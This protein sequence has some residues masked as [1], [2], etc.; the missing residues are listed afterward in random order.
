M[1]EFALDTYRFPA[2]VLLATQ[3]ELRA[4][5][6]ERRAVDAA[7]LEGEAPYFFS[8]TISNNK[9]DSYY[10]RMAQSTLRNYAEDAAAGV[11]FLY[12]HDNAEIV[13]RSTDGRFVGAQ[14]NGVAHVEADFFAVPGLQLGS[15]QSDQVIRALRLGV[16]RDVSVGFYGGELMCSICGRDIM[17]DWECRHYPGFKYEVE[18]DG[19]TEEVI[20]T[21]D[22]ENAR[23][24]EVSGVYKG[25]TP[26]A[27][28]MK[29]E[30]DASEGVIKP[31]ARALIEQRYRIHLPDRRVI[32]PGVGEG[33]MKRETEQN[34]PAEEEKPETPPA[35]PPADTEPEQG[36]TEEQREVK[37]LLT[38]AG[39][40]NVTAATLQTAARALAAECE[41]LRPLADVGTQYRADL[42]A[43]VVREAVRAGFGEE[44]Y[45]GV[46]AAASIETLKRML[47]EFGAQADAVFKPGRSTVDVPETGAREQRR[48]T[49]NAAYAG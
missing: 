49:P 15:V 5:A 44:T 45:K 33:N 18:H 6:L 23:L 21:A 39:V 8:A 36:E 3:D 4:R 37:S 31:E 28:I 14:G 7:A 38:R 25:S 34:A 46:C 10:T 13:G 11:S 47:E 29:A 9:L 26:G 27:V 43:A 19:S 2:A 30:R 32:A 1:S 40:A 20:C 42:T 17:R 22:V 16:I 41:R 12:S 35:D 48:T 24:A